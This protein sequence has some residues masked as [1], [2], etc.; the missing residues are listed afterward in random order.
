[1]AEFHEYLAKHLTDP[2]PHRSPEDLLEEWRIE[3]GDLEAD[4]FDQATHE[5]NVA[6]IREALRDMDSGD[7]GVD[8]HEVIRELDAEL[9]RRMAQ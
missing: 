3:R 1:L 7:E 2:L 4:V 5:E 6:A 8:A 9:R